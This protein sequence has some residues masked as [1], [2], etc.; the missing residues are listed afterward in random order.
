[1]RRKAN[2][3][4]A[5][6]LS[7]KISFFSSTYF[8]IVRIICS[9]FYAVLPTI[10]LFLMK[11]II[12]ALTQKDHYLTFAYVGY[13]VVMLLLSVIVDKVNSYSILLHNERIG[14]YVSNEIINKVSE[15]DISYFDNPLLY[16][17]MNLATKNSSA[18]SGL[19][20]SLISLVQGIIQL[21]LSFVIIMKVG[22]AYAV[23]LIVTALPYFYVERHNETETYLWNRENENHVRKINYLYRILL[24]RYYAF[25]LKVNSLYQFMKK[26]YNKQW[27]G[28]FDNKK[29][30]ILRQFIFSFLTLL[31]TNVV[32][33]AF[34][35]LLVYNVLNSKSSIGDFTYYLGVA[36][37]LVNYTYIVLGGVASF[38]QIKMK[39]SSYNDFMG[40]QSHVSAIG[41]ETIPKDIVTLRFDDV[42]FAYPQN[43]EQS[44]K[45]V[46]FEIRLGEKVLII[47]NNGSGKSTLIKLL[48]RLYTPDS[49]AIYLNDKRIEE[50]SIEEYYGLF[51]SLPQNY[52]NYAFSAKENIACSENPDMNRIKECL[53]RTDL[54]ELFERLPN[55]IETYLTK[56]FDIEGVE[57]S[58]GE[59]QKMAMARFFYKK[60]P[61][62]VLDE[63]S[64]SLD[65][66]AQDKTLSYILEKEECTVLLISHRL[67]PLDRIDKVISLVDGTIV[68][69]GSP[70]MLV[71]EDGFFS[72]WLSANETKKSMDRSLV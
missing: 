40:W 17:E 44:L 60:A 10:K 28:W 61:L 72:N 63:P 32:A 42:S 55:G 45:H 11:L 5:I 54:Y 4:R 25:D 33:L 51:S 47:G 52:V 62:L 58:V 35:F 46:S 65:V 18:I 59:W 26:K 22:V 16:D 41:K 29:N 69:M 48:M 50:Y 43:S 70:E 19:F 57:L 6:L 49:G 64:S 23:I 12:D 31:L 34:V 3:F 56:Q 37:Q 27:N 1:M 14:L 21:V 24:D 9:L 13:Y 20:W 53:I 8:A 36:S 67:V 15:L 71:K 30:L 68:E 38:R 39:T 2:M 7:M 66:F